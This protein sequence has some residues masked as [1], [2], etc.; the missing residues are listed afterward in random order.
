MEKT[1]TQQHDRQQNETH[2][3]G[4]QKEKAKQTKEIDI[5]NQSKVYKYLSHILNNNHGEY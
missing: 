2:N 5:N 3:G 1:L 4:C